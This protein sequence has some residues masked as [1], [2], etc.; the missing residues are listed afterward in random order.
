V[1]H[2]EI[3]YLLKYLNRYLDLH[4]TEQDIV[5]TYAGY[6]PLVKPRDTNAPTAKLSRTH[7]VLQSSSGMVSIVGGKLT[8]YRRM[9][10]DTV[11]VL[12]R[13]DNTK[14]VHPT[15]S[16]PLQGGAG[17]GKAQGEI[18]QRGAAL[19]LTPEMIQHMSRSYGSVAHTVFDLIEQDA[20]L[21]EPLIADLPYVKAEAVYAC[22]YEM[23]MTPEDILSRRTSIMLEDRQRGCG[24][25]GEVAAVMAQELGWSLTQQEA[26]AN[27]YLNEV[28]SQIAVEK[29]P[30][31]PGVLEEG[32][33][34]P[35]PQQM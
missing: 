2:E 20:A 14:P 33:V 27:D 3:A 11:D 17:W 18:A 26:L 13:R 25:V 30:D 19:G 9:A 8:T 31:L 23:A 28:Q 10:Q 4:L 15:Q 22:R 7:A 34:S 12:S 29:R 21:A 24:V 35:S 5:S 16:L 6:R 1:T 32:M